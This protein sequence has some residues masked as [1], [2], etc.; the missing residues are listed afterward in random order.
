MP[1]DEAAEKGKHLLSLINERDSSQDEGAAENGKHL[2]SLINGGTA[3]SGASKVTG[4]SGAD[5][6][7]INAV[8]TLT[9]QPK[10]NGARRALGNS[11]VHHTHVPSSNGR[12]W[13]SPAA[14]ECRE[15]GGVYD[16][17]GVCYHLGGS[18]ESGH[19]VAAVKGPNDQWWECNDEQCVAVDAESVLAGRYIIVSN[20]VFSVACA[21][22][23][24]FA[25]RAL[26]LVRS[27]V[28]VLSEADTFSILCLLLLR[29]YP[30]CRTPTVRW[31]E[32]D[33]TP[34]CTGKSRTAYVVVYHRRT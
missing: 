3:S 20:L 30:M 1:T 19:Y 17:T 23:C 2:L 8:K 27:T 21:C 34:D 12:M 18:L 22:A 4:G 7:A 25:A 31:H 32:G 9:G 16:L 10:A 13:E 29:V 26:H 11:C 33:E 15:S 24:M 14:V 5:E 6:K 28:C